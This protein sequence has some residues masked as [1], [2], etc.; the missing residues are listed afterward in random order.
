MTGPN[1][2]LLVL[3]LKTSAHHE[4]W[5]LSFYLGMYGWWAFEESVFQHPPPTPYLFFLESP[6]M[7]WI[8]DQEHGIILTGQ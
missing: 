3:G 8:T 5:Q 1:K 6:N 2:V 4:D 7:F